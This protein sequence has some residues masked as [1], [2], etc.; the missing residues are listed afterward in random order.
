MGAMIIAIC[1]SAKLSGPQLLLIISYRIPIEGWILEFPGGLKDTE[2]IADCAVREL[3]EETG[4]IGKAR[5]GSEKAFGIYTDPWK[6][7]DDTAIVV[8]DVDLDAKENEN[9]KQ[10]LDSDENIKVIMVPMK[11]LKDEI[12]KLRIEKGLKVS[13]NLWSFAEGLQLSQSFFG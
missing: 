11:N 7:N 6:S 8:I 13:S 1:K 5:P 3:K 10:K 2:N 9:P 4:Y 12:Q